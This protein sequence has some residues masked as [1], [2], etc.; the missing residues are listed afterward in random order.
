MEVIEEFGATDIEGNTEYKVKKT[1][2]TRIRKVFT[3]LPLWLN[4]F[5]WFQNIEVLERKHI[6]QR[7]YYDDGWSYQSYW[8]DPYDKWIK[9]EIL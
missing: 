6:V 3:Y 7:K 2:E 1:D 5:S 4:K 8:S 9:E